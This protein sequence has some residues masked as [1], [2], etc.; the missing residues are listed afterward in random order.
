MLADSCTLSLKTQNFHWNVA[1]PT[2]HTLHVVFEQ[3]YSDLTVAVDRIAE[4]IRALGFPAPGSYKAL[5]GCP[6]SKRPKTC[7]QQRR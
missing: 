1:G 5:R 6:R 2:F 7:L 3:R 4:R